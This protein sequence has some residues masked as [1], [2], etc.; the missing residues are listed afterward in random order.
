MGILPWWGH[1]LVKSLLFIHTISYVIKPADQRAILTKMH[2]SSIQTQQLCDTNDVYLSAWL[3]LHRHCKYMIS[4]PLEWNI[5]PIWEIMVVHYH[6]YGDVIMGVLVSQTTSLM[7]INSTVHSGADQRKQQKSESL[8]VVWRI[9]R[10][11]G[12]SPHKWP[13]LRK[14][15]SFWWRHHHDAIKS[16]RWSLK[17]HDR[18]C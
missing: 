5:C 18:A 12:N 17:K 8:S 11:P 1:V 4:V 14:M 16:R 13:V 10:W 9:H 2:N 7:I 15:F 3:S 6:Q